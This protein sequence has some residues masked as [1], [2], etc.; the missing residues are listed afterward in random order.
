MPF[1]IKD[2]TAICSAIHYSLDIYLRTMS[3][4]SLAD[5]LV[6]TWIENKSDNISMTSRTLRK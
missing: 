5:T 1:L 6:S 2:Q 3:A 4:Y